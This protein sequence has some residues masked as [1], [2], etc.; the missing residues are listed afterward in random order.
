MP[1]KG[2]RDFGEEG[3]GGAASGSDS[4]DKESWGPKDGGNAVKIKHILCEKH[5]KIME[6]L[7]KLKSGMRFN[8]AAVQSSEDEAWLGATWVGCQR[9]HGGPFSE[10]ALAVP[11]SGLDKPL[12]TDT[13]FK[14]KK[15]AYII[16]VEGR[17]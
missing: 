11:V 13:F 5:G 4:S 7:E 1:P 3:D 2:K 8:E 10:A 15:S 16:M 6:P 14:K 17:K 12:F 9:A